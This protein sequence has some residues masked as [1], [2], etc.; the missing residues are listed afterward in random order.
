[1][2]DAG[3]DPNIEHPNDTCGALVFAIIGGQAEMVRLLIER[4]ADVNDKCS[5]GKSALGW[6][7]QQGLS[8]VQK[9]SIPATYLFYAGEGTLALEKA[10]LI[11]E[12]GEVKF[13]VPEWLRQAYK[14]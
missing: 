11:Q 1:M 9:M 7:Q 3:L 10:E 12:G 5:D 14:R 6:A 13:A 8:E 4:G 2:L